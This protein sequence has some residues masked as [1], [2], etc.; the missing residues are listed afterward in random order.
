MDGDDELLN[1]EEALQVPVSAELEDEL[2][3]FVLIEDVDLALSRAETLDVLADGLRELEDDEA[4]DEW[5]A[6]F[7]E[8][9]F[10]VSQQVDGRLV[11]SDVFPLTGLV[12]FIPASVV[13]VIS[14]ELVAQPEEDRESWMESLSDLTTE[15]LL[16]LSDEEKM[17]GHLILAHELPV[18]ETAA[19][20]VEL[21]SRH[22]ELH[23]R[24]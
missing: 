12:G 9:D 24:G 11:I 19:D 21:V 3:A 5:V 13:G 17:V 6:T 23:S 10:H 14:R 15:L 7:G 4:I 2:E 16:L 20:H 18:E 22:A 8:R 1:G